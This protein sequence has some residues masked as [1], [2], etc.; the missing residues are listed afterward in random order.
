MRTV[1]LT[2]CSTLATQIT[3]NLAQHESLIEQ[4]ERAPVS[5]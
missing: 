2:E 4:R 3:P 5:W 1:L